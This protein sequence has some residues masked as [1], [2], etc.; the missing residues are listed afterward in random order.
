MGIRVRTCRIHQLQNHYKKTPRIFLQAISLRFATIKKGRS[1]V[2][3]KTRRGL[4]QY[5]TSEG[6]GYFAFSGY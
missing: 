4:G 2:S 1:A 3:G 5:P 6:I